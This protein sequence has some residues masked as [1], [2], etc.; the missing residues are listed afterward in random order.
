M[1][2]PQLYDT[3]ELLIDLPEHDLRAGARGAVVHKHTDDQF[4]IEFATEE[5]ET[6]A[7]SALS[8]NQFIVVWR[9]ETEEWVPVADQIAQIV[10]NLSATSREEVRDF[11]HFLTIKEHSQPVM[12]A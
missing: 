7:L 1:I 10:T 3:I 12:P 8:S 6:I 4:E 5:G 11:A 2:T 9:A